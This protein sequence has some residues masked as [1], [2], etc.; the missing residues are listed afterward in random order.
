M[1]NIHIIFK[2]ILRNFYLEATFYIFTSMF[3]PL[4][5]TGKS[6]NLTELEIVDI[7]NNSRLH[8]YSPIYGSHISS[9]VIALHLLNH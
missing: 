4:N 9:I 5:E 3:C 8:P 6:L 1:F 2:L 7:V